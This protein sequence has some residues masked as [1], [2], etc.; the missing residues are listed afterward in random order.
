MTIRLKMRENIKVNAEFM[1][2]IDLLR[3]QC[4]MNKIKRKVKSLVILRNLNITDRSKFTISSSHF[5]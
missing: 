2:K 1:V 5:H 4:A 3:K